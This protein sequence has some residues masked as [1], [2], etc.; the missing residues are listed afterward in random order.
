M[1]S[2]KKKSI[3]LP[4]V[5]TRQRAHEGQDY[6]FYNSAAWRR[7]SAAIRQQR[8]V[9]EVCSVYARH[10]PAQMVD[11]II[12]IRQG[13]ARFHEDNLMAMCHECHNRKSAKDSAKG[14]MVAQ[15]KEVNSTGM[16]AQ[17]VPAISRQ[18]IIK[19]IEE[20]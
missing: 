13:G 15:V 9:C 2:T 12:P 3:A 6:A 7:T 8:P 19:L 17:M 1:P 5:V 4:W 14:C 16:E 11:H 10:Q 18:A 20:K